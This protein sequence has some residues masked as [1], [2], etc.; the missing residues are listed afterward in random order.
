MAATSRGDR[1]GRSITRRINTHA[2]PHR[3]EATHSE[4]RHSSP[5]SAPRT[6][7][8]TDPRPILS[9]P[10]HPQPI[11]PKPR[12]PRP[13]RRCPCRAA[14]HDSARDLGQSVDARAPSS[15]L[16]AR[17]RR[18][19]SDAASLHLEGRSPVDAALLS[20][21]FTAAERRRHGPPPSRSQIRGSTVRSQPQRSSVINKARQLLDGE[22]ERE[23]G[24]LLSNEAARQ[25]F[26]SDPERESGA[27]LS[28]GFRPP[29]A[30]CTGVRPPIARR[31]T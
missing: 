12:H 26:D 5:I 8:L 21:P 13:I 20:W 15:T 10:R 11:R 9:K 1:R 19:P 7:L 29:N 28:N 3:S 31:R 17:T 30:R 18:V 23:S 24:A 6:S 2:E 16:M 14:A 22:P 4:P 25:V 27:L